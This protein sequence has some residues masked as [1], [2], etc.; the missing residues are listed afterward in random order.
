MSMFRRVTEWCS[1]RKIFGIRTIT[2]KKL[3]ITASQT[4]RETGLNCGNERAHTM[5]HVEREFQ[6]TYIDHAQQHYELES[7]NILSWN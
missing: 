7:R 4:N 3:T 5:L 2:K 1:S 6:G